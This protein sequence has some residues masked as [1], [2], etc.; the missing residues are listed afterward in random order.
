MK[1]C[2]AC[3]HGHAA[4][5]QAVARY[6][7]TPAELGTS[8]GTGMKKLD[9]QGAAHQTAK[10]HSSN[11]AGSARTIQS[12]QQSESF[13]EARTALQHHLDARGS[14][15]SLGTPSSSPSS[16]YEASVE[17]GSQSG[18]N[19][20][21]RRVLQLS[22]SELRQQQQRHK[23]AERQRNFKQKQKQ[24]FSN[25]RPAGADSEWDTASLSSLSDESQ[26]NMPGPHTPLPNPRAAVSP[27]ANGIPHQDQ[28][29]SP[30]AASTSTM[31]SYRSR[32]GS[33][34][35]VVVNITV[36]NDMPF[37]SANAHQN[38]A[39]HKPGSI[40]LQPT[41]AAAVAAAVA[42]AASSK[43]LPDVKLPQTNGHASDGSMP[44][45]PFASAS[46]QK[47]EAVGGAEPGVTSASAAP[48]KAIDA[49]SQERLAPSPSISRE[50]FPTAVAAVQPEA[51]L[52]KPAQQELPTQDS[53]KADEPAVSFAGRAEPPVSDQQAATNAS[54]AT[55]AAATSLAPPPPPPPPPLAAR[56]QFIPAPPPPPPPA[57]PRTAGL[58][59]APCPPPTG[60]RVSRRR[61]R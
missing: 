20:S 55:D 11:Q 35:R 25:L 59:A 23:L 57:A 16:D 58:C 21:A 3:R 49:G 24:S 1:S 39:K 13:R 54:E 60:N 18:P 12:P 37:Q 10:G 6:K 32:E 28:P 9:L 42:A 4:L 27:A 45:S 44:T 34:P 40:E 61:R 38:Q 17:S 50:L 33:M 8:T 15:D 30:E 26:A 19:S 51:D 43:R 47:G 48:S 7:L 2:P 31:I 36:I 56:A 46:S 53:I 41:G 52:A 14:S 5:A 22:P 29:S